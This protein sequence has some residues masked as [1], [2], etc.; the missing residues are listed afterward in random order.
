MIPSE[1]LQIWYQEYN[2]NKPINFCVILGLTH[3]AMQKDRFCSHVIMVFCLEDLYK[4]RTSSPFP[5]GAYVTSGTLRW[6]PS[7]KP[8]NTI[9]D[10]EEKCIFIQKHYYLLK[11]L[12]L[13][14]NIFWF[15]FDN[16]WYWHQCNFPFQLWLS[17]IKK[18]I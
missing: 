1:I 4:W 5:N 16:K 6:S 14:L 13:F 11:N 12:T 3:F 8:V 2:K 17:K 9:S 10:F 7:Y 15:Y 18:K